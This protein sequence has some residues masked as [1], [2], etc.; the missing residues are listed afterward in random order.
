MTR[1]T[2][3]MMVD[4][5]KTFPQEERELTEREGAPADSVVATPRETD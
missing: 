2:P 3:Q 5:T 1:V 4:L